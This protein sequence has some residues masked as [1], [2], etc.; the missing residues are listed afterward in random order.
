METWACI[1]P[2]GRILRAVWGRF[3]GIVASHP[4]RSSGSGLN[5]EPI[6]VPPADA[7]SRAPACRRS[8]GHVR[9]SPRGATRDEGNG[10][11]LVLHPAED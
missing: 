10:L 1:K 6:D 11:L 3:S 7:C 8:C 4:K 5:R 9:V 2:P